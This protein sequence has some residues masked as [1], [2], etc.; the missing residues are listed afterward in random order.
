MIDKYCELLLEDIK[1]CADIHYWNLIAQYNNR[2][3]EI[4]KTKNKEYDFYGDVLID[5]LKVDE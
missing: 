4:N 5:Y 3:N 2:M 1:T